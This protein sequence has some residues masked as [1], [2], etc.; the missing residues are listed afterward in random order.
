MRKD[1]MQIRSD[2]NYCQYKEGI[3]LVPIFHSTEDFV[4]RYLIAH[5]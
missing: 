4:D 2:P 1:L 3:D 5:P